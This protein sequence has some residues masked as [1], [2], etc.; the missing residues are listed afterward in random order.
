M[1]TYAEGSCARV[2]YALVIELSKCLMLFDQGGRKLLKGRLCVKTP[3][4]SNVLGAALIL[5]AVLW[6]ER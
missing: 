4:I 1:T 5:K 3:Q 2:F 6:Y